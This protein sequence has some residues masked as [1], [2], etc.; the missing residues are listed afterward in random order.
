MDAIS[1]NEEQRQV[2]LVKP[3]KERHYGLDILRWLASVM[4]L[5]IHSSNFYY[6]CEFLSVCPGD[7]PMWAAALASLAR[8]S[9]PLFMML[10]GYFVLPMKDGASSFLK[11]RFMR[12]FLP[13]A[14]WCVIYAGYNVFLKN[15]NWPGFFYALIRIP[16]NYGTEVGHLWYIQMAIGVDLFIPIITPWLTSSNKEG[17]LYFL[18]L[19]GVSLF[20]PYLHLIY[21]YVFG[22][23]F[24][25]AIHTVYYFTGYLGYAVLGQYIR[26][27]HSEK[28]RWDTLVG[29]L[30]FFIGGW[31]TMAIFVL[32]IGTAKN[33]I[34]LELSWG[35]LTINVAIM[36]LGSLV[37]AG[38]KS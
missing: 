19:W 22:E 37:H 9:V 35:Y 4:V 32:R 17:Y 15:L 38:S 23:A 13:Y 10:T 29:F 18:L 2:L 24:W 28:G 21:Y 3:E 1:I 31:L 14:F 26:K 36:S 11:K 33:V 12:V 20:L 6:S 7:G 30:C 27:F 5:V 16:L 8:S 34:E 25:N